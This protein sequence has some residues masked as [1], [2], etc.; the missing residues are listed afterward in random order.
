MLFNSLEFM[1]FFPL[2]CAVYFLLHDNRQRV[3][4]LLLASYI[5]YMSWKPVYAVLILSSTVITYFCGLLVDRSH[6]VARR[7]LV[8]AV[9]LA[10]NLALLFVFK[11]YNFINDTVFALMQSVGWGW[12]MPDLDI[13][14]PVGISF[15][16]FQAVG[17]AVDVYRGK[18][19]AESNFLNYALFVSFFPQLVAGPI[20]RAG[21]LLPQMR[22]EHSFD[23]S[24]AVEGLKMML[25]GYFMKVCV[26]DSAGE[27]VD[28]VYGN[29][30]AHNGTSLLLATVLFSIQIYCDF[31][32]YS[33]IA[34]GAARVMGF[35]LME[36]FRRPYFASNMT[37]FWKRWHISLSTWFMDYVYIP[38]GGNRVAL[39]RH[40][41]NLMVTF[42]LSGL[43][44]GASWT[45]VLWGAWHGVFLILDKMIRGSRKPHGVGRAVSTV[46][47]VVVVVLGWVFFRATDV[48]DAFTVLFS[49]FTNPGKPW[50]GE[51]KLSLALAAIVVLMVKDMADEW[52]PQRKLGYNSPC[53]WV[54]YACYYTLLF[55]TLCMMSG[56]QAF[57]Y[58]QF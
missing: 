10:L 23:R 56:R 32:G 47:V 2:V 3:P 19:R 42:L 7:K 52:F 49:I 39:G 44:H 5:F 40:L 9:G 16:T 54:R 38:L 11:Y 13:L 12:R 31:G 20:E 25:W 21:N 33:L 46:A 18:I 8:L 48:N 24:R 30:A 58:F 28:A 1:L 36:N 57:I 4:M 17:Y 41:F 6:A 29:I 27:Y 53:W 51:P 50:L 34:R 35:R 26:A 15:Y 45:F 43:W 14:L 55:W 22:E 37:E